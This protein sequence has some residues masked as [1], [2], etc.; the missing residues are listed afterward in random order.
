MFIEIGK[1]YFI[2]TVTMHHVGRVKDLNDQEILL[3]DAA[4]IADS[5]RFSD[6]LK[7]GVFSEVEPFHRPVVVSRASLIDYT[8]IDVA[9]P[10]AQK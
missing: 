6:A 5:G 10:L 2:R 8:E 3:E 4:W 9:L 7:T 1:T